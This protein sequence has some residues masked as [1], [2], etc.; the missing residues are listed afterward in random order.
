MTELHSVPSETTTYNYLYDSALVLYDYIA[1]TAKNSV[2]VTEE[3][4]RYGTQ[5]KRT[6]YKFNANSIKKVFCQLGIENY[7]TY[8]KIWNIVRDSNGILECHI[9]LCNYSSTTRSLWE[10]SVLE[11]KLR[12]KEF[13]EKC[14]EAL[15]KCNSSEIKLFL[16]GI[17]K[18]EQ[19]YQGE[20]KHR[21]AKF[22]S[23]LHHECITF[24]TKTN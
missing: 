9:D 23:E 13:I 17:K 1:E 22:F 15:E 21:H 16:E 24:L 18:S 6:Y 14:Y 11:F 20:Y 19:K 10:Q 5:E 8:K 4:I 12:D 2:D 7:N 3:L